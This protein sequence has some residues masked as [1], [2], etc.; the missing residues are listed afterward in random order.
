MKIAKLV[1]TVNRGYI[2]SDYLRW[3]DCAYF[4]DA[5]IDDINDMLQSKYPTFSEWADFCEDWNNLIMEHNFPVH[6]KRSA[7]VYDAF[8]DQYL[9]SVVALGTAVK[10]YE[11]DEEGEQVAQQYQFKYSQALFIMTRDFH[12]L[13]PRFFTD[14]RGGFIDFTFIEEA[15]PRDR[16]PR[17]VEM[18]GGN[19]REI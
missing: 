17:G 6:L 2:S 18:P 13:V 16:K 3:P 7:D 12:E 15:G 1:D 19:T 14:N 9:R 4:M 10:F 5:V 11:R 8:P